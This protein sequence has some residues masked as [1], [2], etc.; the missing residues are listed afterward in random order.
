MSKLKIEDKAFKMDFSLVNDTVI[1]KIE[2]I[3]AHIEIILIA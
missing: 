1:M 3:K 2:S